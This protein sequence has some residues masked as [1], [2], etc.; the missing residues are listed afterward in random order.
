MMFIWQLRE[1]DDVEPILFSACEDIR[2]IAETLADCT[3]IWFYGQCSLG[4]KSPPRSLVMLMANWTDGYAVR[5]K[6]VQLV[7]QFHKPALNEKRLRL[8]RETS[9]DNE[10]FKFTSRRASRTPSTG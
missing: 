6:H 7:R 5:H 10:K 9:N 3:G 1:Y 4:D 8:V 2:Y